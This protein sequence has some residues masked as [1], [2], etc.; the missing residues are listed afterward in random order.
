MK[1][2]S[3]GLFE[4]IIQNIADA[5]VVFDEDGYIHYMN[6]TAEELYDQLDGR[7]D[8]ISSLFPSVPMPVI[9]LNSQSH[10]T[11][12]VRLPM[13]TGQEHQMDVSWMSWGVHPDRVYVAILRPTPRESGYLSP[14]NTPSDRIV[15]ENTQDVISF[16]T[17]DGI[18]Q[19]V[20]PVVE[21]VLGYKPEELVGVHVM[22]L[23]HPD[24][25]KIMKSIWR[26]LRGDVLTNRFCGRVR[27]KNGDYV[28]METTLTRVQDA[29]TKSF[30]V[31]SVSRDIG[32]HMQ[33]LHQLEETIRIAGI[34]H[35][36][37]DIVHDRV[38]WSDQMYQIFG[39]RPG[40]IELTFDTVM[41][42]AH[43][44]DLDRLSRDIHRR[45]QLLGHF[46]TDWRV[47]RKDGSIRHIHAQGKVY[48]D[49]SGNPTHL[50]GTMHDVTEIKRAD[51]LLLR[52]EKLTALGQLAAGIAHEI[53]NPLTAL[54]GFTQLLRGSVPVNQQSYLDIMV[55]ELT[56]IERILSEL[57]VLAKPQAVFFH[58][59]DITTILHEVL[60]IIHSQALLTNVNIHLDVEPQI[61][62][63]N[64]EPNQLK[65]VFVNVMKN[66]IEAMPDGGNL[67]IRLMSMEDNFILIEITDEGAGIPEELIPKLGEPFFTTKDKGTGLGLMTSSKIVTAHHGRLQIRSSV[68]KGTAVS[69][70]LPGLSG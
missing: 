29:R 31:L 66:A 40:E 15:L 19:Y 60:P 54:K 52:S 49:A 25:E 50:V 37:W 59:N 6:R 44:D 30:Q 7:G 26:D 36:E 11:A 9:L 58:P 32:E 69:I 65:Q 39:V 53:R 24:D 28:W 27:H 20:S 22:A 17:P 23:F 1:A 56:R 47:V 34:G 38:V 21:T 68:G 67:T 3:P 63:V 57:L 8:Q 4:I 55:S 35:W 2:L 64:C 5:V 62:L 18:C 14:P 45:L 13:S 16:E 42:F 41:S 48:C 33:L 46:D 70:E 51:E 10:L 43:P 61:P 12:Q